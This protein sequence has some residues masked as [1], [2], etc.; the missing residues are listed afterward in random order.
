VIGLSSKT[1]GKNGKH[2]P[3]SETSKISALSNIFVQVFQ[4]R[5]GCQFRAVTQ[6][7][8]SVR[9]K[10]FQLLPSIQF[11]CLTESPP[12]VIGSGNAHSVDTIIEVSQADV[13]CY[14]ALRGVEKNLIEAL[15]KW[16]KR[17]GDVVEDD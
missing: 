4:H 10:H 9:T 7:T 5:F 11:L 16:K 17:G 13:E 14:Q 15:K 8:T 2:C 3:V 6:A 12:K 1:G